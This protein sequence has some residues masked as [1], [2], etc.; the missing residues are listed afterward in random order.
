MWLFY[1]AA[2]LLI[3]NAAGQNVGQEN[4]TVSLDF[5]VSVMPICE[6]EVKVH[7]DVYSKLKCSVDSKNHSDIT[8][9]TVPKLP[10]MIQNATTC[11]LRADDIYHC[12]NIF[13]LSSEYIPLHGT[14]KVTCHAKASGRSSVRCLLLG[15]L[16]PQHK[17]L[18]K[19]MPTTTT[20]SSTATRPGVGPRRILHDFS[21]ETCIPGAHQTETA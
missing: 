6:T 12:T 7:R 10:E 9:S 20:L 19:M 8:W 1:V 21:S 5:V 4:H 16:V 3:G 18:L 17:V 14:M 15:I 13:M 11:N 2:V